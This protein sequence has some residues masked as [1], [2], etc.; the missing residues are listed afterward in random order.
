MNNKN[1]WSFRMKPR[2]VNKTIEWFNGFAMIEGKNWDEDSIFV[3][4]RSGKTV[5]T[6]RRLYLLKSHPELLEDSKAS[7]QDF[8]QGIKDPPSDIESNARN[9]K[10]S[11][12][13]FGFGYVDKAG[14]VHSTSAGDAIV[15]KRFNDEYLLKQML[16]MY[17]SYDN[18]VQALKRKDVSIF[19]MQILLNVILKY[20]EISKWEMS[21]LFMCS[22]ISNIDL[23]YSSIDNF[24]IK[25]NNL[26]NKRKTSDVLN[27]IEE[28]RNKYFK[29]ITNK[30]FSFLD[31]SDSF[32]RAL[33]Y[34]GLFL[35]RGRGNYSKI[36]V[37]EHA[38]IKFNLLCEKYIF[39]K[40]Y[41][42]DTIDSYMH[43]YGDPY[44]VILPW[45][46]ADSREYIVRTK[47]NQLRA[48]LKPIKDS[49]ILEEKLTHLNNIEKE[50]NNPNLSYENLIKFDEML[51]SDILNIN[52]K[53]FI[54][55]DSKQKPARNEIIRKF[56]DI[57]DGNE[58]MAALW[59]E[60]NTW[61]SLV[62]I[63]GSHEVKRNF[64]LEL[65]LSPKSFAPGTGN[66]P[67]ME[68]YVNGTIL[69]PEVS[70]MSGVRQWE[71]EG[72][73][74]IDHVYKFIEENKD[75]NVYG[76][77]ISKAMN[78]RTIWQFFIL[79]KESWIGSK[80]PV[81]PFTINQYTEIIKY[82]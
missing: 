65:D 8:L 76:I 46:N 53:I 2:S 13:F 50:L 15:A 70:L 41:N 30:T 28:V 73:S 27:I 11:F 24:R 1:S 3:S 10:A 48:I 55:I 60:V 62:A 68:L 80:V 82:I 81:I 69:V 72:S 20:K 61:K 59:L 42:L 6:S 18:P 49:L 25:Y 54:E 26:K 35:S 16:K 77:F 45:D 51:S 40:P 64:L 58:D 12:E 38:K 37:P 9:D 5:K 75:K 34:T 43:W 33:T 79:N 23:V 47:V 57:D 22:N 36:Y 32:L 67:D 63:S 21:F 78:V 4:D 74:V 71:H 44:N 56:G 39:E 66:T 29:E 7:R 17:I 31:Y 52:E 19:P 14:I